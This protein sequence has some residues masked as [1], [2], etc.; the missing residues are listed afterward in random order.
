MFNTC[1]MIWKDKRRDNYG[2]RRG[3]KIEKEKEENGG[4]ENE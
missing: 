2:I 4:E 1:T 3:E